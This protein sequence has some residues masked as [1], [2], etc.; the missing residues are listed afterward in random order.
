[1]SRSQSRCRPCGIEIT[2]LVIAHRAVTWRWVRGSW[3]LRGT[4]GDPEH[5]ELDRNH[6]QMSRIPTRLP[7]ALRHGQSVSTGGVNVP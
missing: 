1:M 5:I 4:G 6:R 3:V 2:H 7:P